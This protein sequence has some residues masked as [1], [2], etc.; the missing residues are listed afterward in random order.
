MSRSRDIYP[1]H[2]IAGASKTGT[3]WIRMCLRKHPQVYIPGGPT[4]DYFSKFYNK[5]TSWYLSHFSNADETDTVLEKSTSYM[6][7]EKS[8]DR[9]HKFNPNMKFIFILR[10]PIHRAYSHYCMHLKAGKVSK[11]ISEEIHKDTRYVR[12]GFYYKHVKRFEKYFG[13][14]SINIFL[15]DNLKDTPVEFWLNVLSA[16]GVSDEFVPKLVSKK[17]HSKKSLPRY[18]TL[19]RRIVENNRKMRRFSELWN[20][21]FVKLQGMGLTSTL[22][23]IMPSEEFPQL[24]YSHK[25]RLKA[26]YKEDYKKLKKYLDKDISSWMTL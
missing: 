2:L 4:I 22:H 3:E 20:G 7:Y 10:D 24:T 19:Y 8:A 5:D 1:E 21:I 16:I 6:V 12:E 11:K 26:I 25:R 13:S 18:K 15:F 9:I 14:D 23:S 17:I